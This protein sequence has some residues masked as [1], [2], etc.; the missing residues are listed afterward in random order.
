MKCSVERLIESLIGIELAQERKAAE[1]KAEQARK[2]REAEL[3]AAAQAEADARETDRYVIQLTQKV[4]R[5][6]RLCGSFRSRS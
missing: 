6:W 2:A 4:N 5:S 1:E 3:Q